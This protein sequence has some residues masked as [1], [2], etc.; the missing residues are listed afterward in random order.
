MSMSAFALRC[1]K[2]GIC[3]TF[4]ALLHSILTVRLQTLFSSRRE[5]A[6]QYIVDESDRQYEE[7]EDMPDANCEGNCE[8]DLYCQVWDDEMSWVW[9][10]F[11]VTDPLNEMIKG[12]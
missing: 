11:C 2:E 7:I 9:K 3:K 1:Y 4:G 12:E 8:N 5:T 10:G 6:A